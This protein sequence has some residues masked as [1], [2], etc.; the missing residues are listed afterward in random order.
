MKIASDKIKHF[1]ACALVSFITS[2]AEVILGAT[3]SHALI[4]GFI[5]GV[6][7]GVGKEYGDKCAPGNR[8]DWMD[9]AADVLGSV[10]GAAIGLTCYYLN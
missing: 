5:A 1:T 6:A 9:I 4:A 2:I 10:L 8:W 7:V 3:F